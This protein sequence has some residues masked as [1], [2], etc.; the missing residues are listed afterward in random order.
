M[1]GRVV[2]YQTGAPVG[3]ALVRAIH[4]A[5]IAFGEP[6]ASTIEVGMSMTNADGRFYIPG[7][8]SITW[9]APPLAASVG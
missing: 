1:R 9:L 3:G 7:R 6:S 8:V 4:R 2:D 5:G